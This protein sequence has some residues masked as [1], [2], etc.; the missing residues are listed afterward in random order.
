MVINDEEDCFHVDPLNWL[1]CVL[2]ICEGGSS[3]CAAVFPTELLWLLSSLILHWSSMGRIVGIDSDDIAVW[4]AY[5]H[6]FVLSFYFFL[7]FFEIFLISCNESV[8]YYGLRPVIYIFLVFGNKLFIGSISRVLSMIDRPCELHN[9]TISN[10]SWSDI[11]SIP[12]VTPPHRGVSR[13]HEFQ[14]HPSKLR[15]L[16]SFIS[17]KPVNSVRSNQ[18]KNKSPWRFSAWQLNLLFCTLFGPPCNTSNKVDN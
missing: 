15:N 7:F 1:N 3:G 8:V 9:K 6:R 10:Q 14:F 2:C 18:L 11:E 16:P 17:K 4:Y 12:F 5:R 13:P